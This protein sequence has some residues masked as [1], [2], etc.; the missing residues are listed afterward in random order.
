MA[1]A[2]TTEREWVLD[3]G[4]GDYDLCKQALEKVEVGEPSIARIFGAARYGDRR[5][6][7]A[8]V[9]I[10]EEA[11]FQAGGELAHV[12]VYSDGSMTVWPGSLEDYQDKDPLPWVEFIATLG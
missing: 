11:K 9:Q 6:W 3:M 10:W 8:L 4:P 7:A 12:I 5:Q 2:K 1:E